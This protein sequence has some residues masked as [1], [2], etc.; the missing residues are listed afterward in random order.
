MTKAANR[1]EHQAVEQI[2]A[3]IN[4][5]IENQCGGSAVILILT[6][7]DAMAYLTMPRGQED[8]TRQDFIRWADEYIRFPGQEQLTGE[9]LYGARC[10]MLHNY[11]VQSRM[12]RKGECRAI[13]WADNM[14]PPILFR[15]EKSNQHVL[16]SIIGL[17]D[18]LFRGMDRFLAEVD[19]DPNSEKTKLTKERLPS[20][21]VAMPANDLAT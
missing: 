1:P 4:V 19:A 9:D 11:G 3:G 14:D 15:P 20:L 12:S 13:L 16:V 17:K 21:V 8:V 5:T 18:A 10:A 2:K 6:A 7:I